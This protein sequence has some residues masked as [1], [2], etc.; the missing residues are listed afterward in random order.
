MGK[1]DK[2]TK[3]GKIILGSHGVT[4][5]KKTS[6]PVMAPKKEEAVVAEVKTPAKT[7]KPKTTKKPKVAAPPAP[8][9][10]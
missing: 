9:T 8:E 1:G 3:R 10:T 2:K 7:T 6:K 4:R 5:P